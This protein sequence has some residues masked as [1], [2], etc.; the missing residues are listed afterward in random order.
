MPDPE[1]VLLEVALIVIA[2]CGGYV[3]GGS[4]MVDHVRKHVLGDEDRD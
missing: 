1:R 2:W 3:V 4:D